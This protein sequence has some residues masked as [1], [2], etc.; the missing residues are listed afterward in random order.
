MELQNIISLQ[1]NENKIGNTYKILIDRVEG[2]YLVGRTD[3]DSPEIDQEV[4]IKKLEKPIAS[5][6][7]L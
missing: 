1:N 3:F 7:F 2:D 6:N 4:L 5:G